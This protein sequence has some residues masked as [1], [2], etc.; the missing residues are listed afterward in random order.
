[1]RGCEKMRRGWGRLLGVG[2]IMMGYRDI[3][4]LGEMMKSWGG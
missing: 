2:E 4:G 3:E 1:M